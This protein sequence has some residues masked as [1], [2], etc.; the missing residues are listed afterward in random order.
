MIQLYMYTHTYISN[1]LIASS[2]HQI[3]MVLFSYFVSRYTMSPSELQELI[4]D[5]PCHYPAC[6][7]A[8]DV[9]T[10]M[11]IHDYYNATYVYMCVG[12]AL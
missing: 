3:E 5:I 4:M 10:Y 6:E 11:Y 8:F 2:V 9:Y 7:Y 12:Q 1:N